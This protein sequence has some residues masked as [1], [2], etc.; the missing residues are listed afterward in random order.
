MSLTDMI[1]INL[2]VADVAKATAFYEA[3]GA[4]KNPKFSDDTTSCIVLSDHI[5]V[6]L[7]SRERFGS[8]LPGYVV[9]DP[10]A[11]VGAF[12][13][14][15]QPSK[16][17]V[18]A[19]VDKAGLNGGTTDVTPTQDHGFMLGRSFADPD[20]HLWEVM[21]MDPAAVEHGPGEMAEA[22]A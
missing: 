15:A 6:M 14:I 11:A 17:A 2:P 16:D 9:A 12:L 18:H 22:A 1:F 21:W 7:L 20:G 3:I 10:H 5:H 19:L 13:C 4:T 8:F